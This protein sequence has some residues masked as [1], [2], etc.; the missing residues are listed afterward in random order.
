A[1]PL[2]ELPAA[3]GNFHRLTPPI[4]HRDLKPSNIL[5]ASGGREPPDRTASGGSRRPLALRITD[6]GIGGVA[7]EYMRTHHPQG[8][9]LMTGWLATSLRGSYTPLYASPQQRAGAPPD[10]RDDVHALGVIGFQML[11]G[12]LDQAPG[13]DAAED[14]RDA[15]AGDGLIA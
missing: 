14:L 9:S 12:R 7:V 8:L 10:P 4:V 15:G 1:A 5:L 11:T 2:P 13:I 6:F 3:V